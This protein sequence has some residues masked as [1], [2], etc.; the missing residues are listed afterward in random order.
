MSRLDAIVFLVLTGVIGLGCGSGGSTP[1]PDVV[2]VDIGGDA[3]AD[4]P[5]SPET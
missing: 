4:A 2:P 3:A 1:A 5:P